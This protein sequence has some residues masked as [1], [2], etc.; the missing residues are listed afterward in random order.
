MSFEK[1]GLQEVFQ[2]WKLKD[3]ED[4]K[5]FEA[6]FA[7]IMQ[8]NSLSF[9][10]F[11]AL[12]PEAF[13]AKFKALLQDASVLEQ[14][15]SKEAKLLNSCEKAFAA[16]RYYYD[17]TTLPSFPEQL[18]HLVNISNYFIPTEAAEDVGT[19]CAF[20][21]E[22]IHEQ[23]AGSIESLVRL[24]A[25]VK[26]CKEHGMIDAVGL[27]GLVQ[28][29]PH[30]QFTI[31][32]LGA[33]QIF[34]E[35]HQLAVPDAELDNDTII[36]AMLAAYQHK[37]SQENP[38][39]K[40]NNINQCFLDRVSILSTFLAYIREDVTDEKLRNKLLKKFCDISL[41]LEGLDVTELSLKK[42]DLVVP[43]I[44]N[45][46]ETPDFRVKKRQYVTYFVEALPQFVKDAKKA[47]KATKPLRTSKPAKTPANDKAAEVLPE[48]ANAP[49]KKSKGSNAAKTTKVPYLLRPLVAIA[50]GVWTAIKFVVSVITW[51]FVTAFKAGVATKLW[52]DKR[53]SRAAKASKKPNGDYNGATFAKSFFGFGAVARS[54]ASMRDSVQQ[55][56]VV[57]SKTNSVEDY[58][59]QFTISF[60]MNVVRSFAAGHKLKV[61]A[62]KGTGPHVMP[63]AQANDFVGGEDTTRQLQ[64]TLNAG[65]Q[66]ATVASGSTL[67]ITVEGKPQADRRTQATALVVHGAFA[68]P[69]DSLVYDKEGKLLYVK[70]EPYPFEEDS[71]AI[72]SADVDVAAS[73]QFKATSIR[74]GGSD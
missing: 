57:A 70:M 56:R 13:E 9:V 65:Q 21:G 17:A 60:V 39:V 53:F 38:V 25:K 44:I 58:A 62:V 10:D 48:V 31:G 2:Q 71:A 23:Q 6:V 67:D 34:C 47:K 8:S 59:A 29:L 74:A 12:T 50:G 19:Y 69:E 42:K 26:V 51:P 73:P 5:I 14:D 24:L 46:M 41:T 36:E 45:P 55:A 49:S 68:A 18:S 66:A 28:H 11:V 16:V 3:V 30:N 20:A 35:D 64:G 40:Y 61:D 32:F 63:V 7:A 54:A 52:F 72:A 33:F 15:A 4:A 37:F 1:Q 22:Y 43:F 27:S